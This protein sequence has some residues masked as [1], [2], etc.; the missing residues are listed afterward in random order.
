MGAYDV[1]K[2]DSQSKYV[3]IDYTALTNEKISNIDASPS[4][5]SS[6]S[7]ENALGGR[8]STSASVSYQADSSLTYVYYRININ[9]RDF[10]KVTTFEFNSKNVD[11]IFVTMIYDGTPSLINQ[12]CCF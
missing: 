1:G 11:E 2:C 3:C 6:H 4:S 9:P 12:V 5:D 7:P 8:N 10:L